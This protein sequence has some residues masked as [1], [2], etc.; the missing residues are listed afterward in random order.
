MNHWFDAIGRS[1]FMQGLVIV[2]TLLTYVVA[3]GL[4]CWRFYRTVWRNPQ[5]RRKL[6][7]SWSEA[8][9]RIG[10]V[11]SK[12]QKQRC[13]DMRVRQ[14]KKQLQQL[15]FFRRTH[16][17]D[18]L[19]KVFYNLASAGVTFCYLCINV[20]LF[21]FGFFAFAVVILE[22]EIMHAP[23]PPLHITIGQRI[24]LRSAGVL[25]VVLFTLILWDIGRVH[26]EADKLS[27]LFRD[28]RLARIKSKLKEFG[29]DPEQ[30]VRE[31]R[32]SRGRRRKKEN[33]SD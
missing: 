29:V 8:L 25:F 28:A 13:T 9:A 1:A 2:C 7:G 14:L 32:Q 20:V 18:S 17:M 10:A 23:V 3:I 16:E 27:P 11:F 33:Q 12:S 24:L 22:R 5:A 30:V 15:L 21:G 6:K 19:R 26:V 31:M 4:S